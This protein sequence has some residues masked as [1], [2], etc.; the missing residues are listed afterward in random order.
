VGEDQ[1]QHLELAR[2]VAERF[3]ARFGEV[4]T[5]PD[6][7]IPKVGARILD[8]QE[9]D[10]KMSTT[11]GSEL[12]TVYILDPPDVIARKFRSAVTDSGREVVRAKDKRGVSN[13]VEIMAV[14]RGISAED[15]ERSTRRT[16][17]AAATWA[18]RWRVPAALREA[19]RRSGR[20]AGASRPSCGAARTVRGVASKIC[21]RRG[22]GPRSPVGAA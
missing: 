21:R 11:G 17:P 6:H 7:R 3:N 12:G 22:H 5:V 14:A 2:E 19:S 15:V 1:K 13:L 8:L 18:R 20:R 10:N 4:F 16:G 9:P